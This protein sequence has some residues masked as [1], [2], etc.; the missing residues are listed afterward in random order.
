M[1]YADDV[2]SL[3]NLYRLRMAAMIAAGL[4]LLCALA[5]D[6]HWMVYPRALAWFVAGGASILEGRVC[7]R[8]GRSPDGSYLRAAVFVIAAVANLL[9]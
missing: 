4:M 1:A 3:E 8:L 9:V 5:F 6:M 2:R 7:K